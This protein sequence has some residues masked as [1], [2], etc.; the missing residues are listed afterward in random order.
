[1]RQRIILS[2][3]IAVLS[4]V[5]SCSL[6]NAPPA[7]NSQTDALFRATREGKADMV[8]ALLAAPGAEVNG[9]DERG[10]TPLLEAARF[11]HDD[12]AR[13]LLAAGANVKARDNDGK[14]AL[15]LAVQ[16]GHDEV[17]RILKLAGETE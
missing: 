5:A 4:V 2:L 1:M 9:K 14:T 8:K 15:M 3:S 12:V 16:G 13:V 17:V 7:R 6:Q 10:S 11:G